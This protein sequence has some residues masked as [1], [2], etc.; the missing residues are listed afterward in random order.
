MDDIDYSRFP[1]KEYQTDWLR[2]YLEFY[3]ERRGHHPKEPTDH[4]LDVLYIQ[5]NKFVLVCIV[6]F[7]SLHLKV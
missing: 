6:V 2:I 4:D 5:V 3:Y 1:D 7:I